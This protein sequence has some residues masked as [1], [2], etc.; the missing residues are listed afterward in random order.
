MVSLTGAYNPVPF[1]PSKFCFSNTATSC[2][3][4]LAN[5]AHSSSI[6]RVSD[7]NPYGFV[8]TYSTRLRRLDA[9]LDAFE[10]LWDRAGAGDGRH[11]R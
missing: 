7:A 1:S 3:H 8:D 4:N 9:V 6:A 11:V 5:E 2:S 10:H